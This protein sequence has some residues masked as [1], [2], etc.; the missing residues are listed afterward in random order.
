MLIVYISFCCMG[1]D[2]TTYF[3]T[4]FHHNHLTIDERSYRVIVFTKLG[5]L[6]TLEKHCSVHSCKTDVL[7][8]YIILI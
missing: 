7:F 8:Q 1:H 3:L 6:G 5:T 2:T 4:W